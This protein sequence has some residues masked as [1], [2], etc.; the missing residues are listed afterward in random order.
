MRLSQ[1]VLGTF[2]VMGENLPPAIAAAVGGM[3][4]T[5]VLM[6]LDTIKTRMQ[7]SG[8]QFELSFSPGC[9]GRGGTG[10]DGWSSFI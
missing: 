7:S 6:P 1:Q 10:G 2:F 9:A 3:V 5:T 8:A 4:A